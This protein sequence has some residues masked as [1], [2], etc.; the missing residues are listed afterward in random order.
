MYTWT[1]PFA[2]LE[3]AREREKEREDGARATHTRMHARTQ[4]YT[5]E[6]ERHL[7][8]LRGERKRIKKKGKKSM[9]SAELTQL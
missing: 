8:E 4:A 1:V 2:C 9:L 5:G 7:V 3:R 6:R